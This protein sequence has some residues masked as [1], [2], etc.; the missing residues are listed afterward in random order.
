MTIFELIVGLVSVVFDITA[1]WAAF[2]P[3]L[4][5]T[6]AVIAAVSTRDFERL[7]YRL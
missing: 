1:A 7:D 4:T 5:V 3:G 6:L 2:A